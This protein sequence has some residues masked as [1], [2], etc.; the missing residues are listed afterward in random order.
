MAAKELVLWCGDCL[1]DVQDDEGKGGKLTEKEGVDDR[2]LEAVAGAAW[3][4]SG[5]FVL[6]LFRDTF[7]MRKSENKS[8]E[9]SV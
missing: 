2:A 3:P 6:P 9:W 7:C 5:G 1:E 8:K 4:A